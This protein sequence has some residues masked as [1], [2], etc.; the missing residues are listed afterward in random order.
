MEMMGKYKAHIEVQEI[1]YR[2]SF[3][4]QRNKKDDNKNVVKEYLFVGY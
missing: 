4:N 3:A 1:D 2:Y